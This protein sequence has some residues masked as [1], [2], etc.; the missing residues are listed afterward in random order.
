MGV[1]QTNS[2]CTFLVAG[3]SY[4]IEVLQVQE[5][6]RPQPLT[7]VPLAP[8]AVRGLLNL[9]G[10]VVPA[11][12]L[13]LR[14]LLPARAETVPPMCLIVRGPSGLACLLIDEAG[15]VRETDPMA[16]EPAPPSLRGEA[17][18][19]IRGAFKLSDHLLLIL[20]LPRVLTLAPQHAAGFFAPSAGRNGP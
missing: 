6:L 5:V 9:R 7:P 17:R 20:D 4:G 14:L 11:I 1:P 19:L 2:Y 15:E 16:F 10:Q 18:R 8:P 12:D 3:T 13:R